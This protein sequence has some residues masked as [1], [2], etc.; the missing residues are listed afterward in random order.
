VAF[1]ILAVRDGEAPDDPLY[2]TPGEEANDVETLPEDGNWLDPLTA[3]ELNV[4]EVGEGGPKRLLHLNKMKAAVLVSEQRV[5]VACSKYEKGG[6][7]VPFGGVGSLAVAGVANAASKVKAARRRRGK[8][9]VGHVPYA[10]LMSVGFRPPSGVMQREQLRLSMYDPTES[11]Y[12]ALMLDIT[13]SGNRQ[14]ASFLAQQIACWAASAKLREDTSDTERAILQP[15]LEEP[16]P[17]VPQAKAF[18]SY[19]LVP[20]GFKPKQART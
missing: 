8:M 1:V 14:S 9:L 17:L 2:P 3:I 12:R 16:E 5:A 15:L 13:L 18:S 11:D 19:S 4:A 20:D 7:Y 6:G 10:H